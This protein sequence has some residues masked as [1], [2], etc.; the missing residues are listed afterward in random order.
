MQL[1]ILYVKGNFL[2]SEINLSY[3]SDIF[4]VEE[5][6]VI[7]TLSTCRS[8]YELVNS[9]VLVVGFFCVPVTINRFS[10]IMF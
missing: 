1:I 2:F 3:C 9:P 4:A 6:A 5:G 7:R 10:F 8:L